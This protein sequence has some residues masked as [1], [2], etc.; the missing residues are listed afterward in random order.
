MRSEL[1]RHLRVLAAA[2][3]M[4]AAPERDPHHVDAVLKI[5]ADHAQ[6]AS[7]A[8]LALRRLVRRGAG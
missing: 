7:H 3:A 5:V 6:A 4:L 1:A 2:E 8:A